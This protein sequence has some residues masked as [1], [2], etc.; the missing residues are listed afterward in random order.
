MAGVLVRQWESGTVKAA[1]GFRLSASGF[2]LSASGCRL[3]A[4]SSF[5]AAL[6]MK[7]GW[8][9]KWQYIR[10]PS[11]VRSVNEVRKTGV[12]LKSV[13]IDRDHS[14]GRF[15]DSV[16]LAPCKGGFIPTLTIARND[17]KA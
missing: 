1:S 10:P 11:T 14:D 15:L 7:S 6:R 12:I 8:E 9:G 3:P 5:F 4:R 16:S 17:R 2:R 13:I